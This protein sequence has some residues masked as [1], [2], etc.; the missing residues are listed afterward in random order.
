MKKFFSKIIQY[1]FATSLLLLTPA[2]A[3]ADIVPVPTSGASEAWK[4]WVPR[5]EFFRGSLQ[6]IVSNAIRLLLIAAGVVALIYLILA[7]YKYITAGGNAETAT[8]ARTG[9]LNAIIGLVVI[10]AS[11]LIITFVF[12]RF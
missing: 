12:S 2:S 5:G 1:L 11:Y 3:S 9:I 7:G 4:N 6:S 10:F 8:E